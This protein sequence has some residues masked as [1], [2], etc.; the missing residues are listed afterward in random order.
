MSCSIHIFAEIFEDSHW[1]LNHDLV[2]RNPWY[3]DENEY[4]K[5]ILANPGYLIQDWEKDKYCADP[6]NIQDYEWFGL[7]S[8]IPNDHDPDRRIVCISNARGMPK[9]ASPWWISYVKGWQDRLSIFSYLT[10][11]DFLEFDWQGN[12]LETSC[13]IPYEVYR[14]RNVI[15]TNR[16]KD[17]FCT[18]DHSDYIVLNQRQAAELL[19]E[20]IQELNK[21][22]YTV[23]PNGQ[24][25]IKQGSKTQHELYVQYFYQTSYR[26]YFSKYFEQVISPMIELNRRYSNVRLVF[27]FGLS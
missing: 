19:P 17:Y 15:G 4:K 7:L 6:P 12:T 5:N 9:D 27:A 18:P 25:I 1:K 23:S 3:V 26:N 21:G 16:L 11:Q 8:N 14:N 13:L 22:I 20:E 2:F 10:I 24:L